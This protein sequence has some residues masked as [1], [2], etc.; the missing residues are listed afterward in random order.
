ME[1]ED[2]R[3]TD[4][5]LKGLFHQ[6]NLQIVVTILNLKCDF[7]LLFWFWS[8]C[9]SVRRGVIFQTSTSFDSPNL[10]ERPRPPMSSLEY[11]WD[12]TLTWTSP[13]LPL[14][15]TW[16]SPANLTIIKPSPWWVPRTL[17]QCHLWG[18]MFYVGREKELLKRSLLHFLFTFPTSPPSKFIS[19]V[20]LIKNKLQ[21]MGL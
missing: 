13:G 11:F 3:Q 19:A 7:C 16:T 2:K 17:P 18:L 9:P 6:W 10:I 1:N 21:L 5:K 4:F 15:I 8:I 12:L 14:D 20:D